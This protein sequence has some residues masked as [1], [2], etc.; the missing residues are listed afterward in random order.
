M[1]RTGRHCRGRRACGC[2]GD[3]RGSRES[4][5]RPAAPLGLS[6]HYVLVR[7]HPLPGVSGGGE[8]PLK[9]GDIWI[10]AGDSITAQ[11]LHSNYFEAF[12]F[13][14]YPKLKFAFRNSGVG[15]HTIPTTLARFDYDIAAWKPA[16]VSVELGMN[17]KGAVHPRGIHRQH[18]DDGEADSGDRRPSGNADG[19]LPSTTATR[20]PD[21][22][23]NQRLHDYA[24][25]LKGFAPRVKRSPFADQFHLLID[26]W[27]EEQARE[28]WRT[29]CRC[30]GSCQRT[31]RS[32]GGRGI[33]DIRGGPG[34]PAEEAG[35]DVWGPGP[36]GAPRPGHD[37][38]GTTKELG[39]EAFVSQAVVD[40]SGKVAGRGRARSRMRKRMERRWRSIGLMSRFQFP[41]PVRLRA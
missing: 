16:A 4:H 33:E 24:V 30:S 28:T 17:D 5:A 29:Q 37:G 1:E 2:A 39:A 34:R 35:L 14:R 26:V 23:Q 11:H 40:V 12:C 13:A 3:F 20:W 32:H 10:M 36:S 21:L 9:D 6:G 38:G 15:G 7:G 8:F 25:S 27:G 19:Q 18:D 22:G 31:R 41:I